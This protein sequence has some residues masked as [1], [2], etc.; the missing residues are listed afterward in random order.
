M[1]LLNWSRMTARYSLH[2]TAQCK[3]SKCDEYC[4]TSDEKSYQSQSTLMTLSAQ[5]SK[6]V[7]I[8]LDQ[9]LAYL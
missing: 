2:L 7:M 6:S 1:T 5:K 3:A 4:C 8:L 9:N